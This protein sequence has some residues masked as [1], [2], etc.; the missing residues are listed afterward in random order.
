MVAQG[1]AALNVG[2]VI[3]QFSSLSSAAEYATFLAIAVVV[4]AWMRPFR[5]VWFLRLAFV[6]VLVIALF[7]ESSRGIVFLLV[8]ATGLVIAARLGMRMRNA[9][10]VGLVAIFLLPVVASRLLPQQSSAA[11]GTTSALVAH[12]AT[13][14]ADPTSSNTTFALHASLVFAGLRSALTSPAGHGISV[15]TIAGNKFGGA[16]QNTET[17]VS[18]VGVAMGIAGLA[19]FLVII[20]IGFRSAYGLAL[21]RKDPLA[22]AALG[23]LGV[24]FLEWLNGGQYAIAYLPWLILGWVD[25][26][27]HDGATD[28][29]LPDGLG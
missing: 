24:T 17:D 20:G 26:Q 5:T 27:A 2:G 15:V 13:G 3:R 12:E 22:Y 6:G 4:W 14:L 9:V 11:R 21:I 18:N 28:L 10:A 19:V 25:R 29:A 1:Y 8:G 16:N 23:I 7:Y